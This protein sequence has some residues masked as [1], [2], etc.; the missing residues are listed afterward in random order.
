MIRTVLFVLDAFVAVTAVGGGLA[1]ALG[2]EGERFS[3]EILRRTPF[4]SFTVPGLILAVVVGGSAAA[5]A[6]ATV[7]GRTAGGAA[8]VVAAVLLGG[9][10]VA[11]IALLEDGPG[12]SRT[13]ACYLGV[14]AAMAF[15][16]GWLWWRA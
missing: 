12:V 6:F 15:L 5:A 2:L 4:D 16:G 1:L 9:F 7:E 10:I 3:R 14:A 11:E 8:S 13:E